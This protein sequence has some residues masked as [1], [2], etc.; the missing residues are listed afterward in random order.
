MQLCHTLKEKY[1]LENI[2]QNCRFFKFFVLFLI[3]HFEL[4]F[5]FFKEN[6]LS[7]SYITS[8]KL[9]VTDTKHTECQG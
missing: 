2:K 1:I 9:K 8:K 5:L 3:I 6:D 7:F 4:L